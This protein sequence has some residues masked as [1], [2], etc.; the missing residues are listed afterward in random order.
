[1][2]SFRLGISDCP[3]TAIRGFSVI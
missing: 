3:I 2:D 1:L